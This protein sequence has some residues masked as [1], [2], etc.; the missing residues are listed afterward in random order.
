M[1]EAMP[2]RVHFSSFGLSDKGEKSLRLYKFKFLN[3]FC[4]I[5]PLK[6]NHC[7]PFKVEEYDSNLKMRGGYHNRQ[8]QGSSRDHRQQGQ[9]KQESTKGSRVDAGN[10]GHL[11]CGYNLGTQT[12]Q[13]RSSSEVSLKLHKADRHLLLPEGGIAELERIDPIL[14]EERKE[15]A[16][17]ARKR[18]ADDEAEE[19]AK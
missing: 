13:W 1:N 18:T 14:E 7:G 5:T 2:G 10:S 8:W 4:K 11:I 9:N 16:R 15:K 19:Q 6:T 17:R 12:C 3:F